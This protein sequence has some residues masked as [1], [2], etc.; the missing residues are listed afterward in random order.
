MSPADVADLV[1][2]PRTP[3]PPPIATGP[4][5]L[6]MPSTYLPSR[7]ADLESWLQNFKTLIA[8]APGAY[9][10]AAG[11]ATAITAAY[12]SWHAAYLAAVNP[13]TRTRAT[14]STKNTQRQIVLSLVRGYAATIRV[15]AAVGDALKIGLGLHVHATTPT[16]T[17]IPAPTTKPVLAITH[18]DQGFQ[19]ILAS[20]QLHR[21]QHNGRQ[22]Q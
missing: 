21:R 12:T 5:T 14:V 9:G 8:A 3:P 2:H 7:D 20:R 13:T 16:P 19:D 4:E 11:D 6:A 10:L 18:M 17:P 22:S 15:N 1:C